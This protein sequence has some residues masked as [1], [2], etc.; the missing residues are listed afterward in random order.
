MQDDNQNG[1][2]IWT[3][4][5]FIIYKKSFIGVLLLKRPLGIGG[6]LV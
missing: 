2:T 3:I 1:W 6:A 5:F 4:H